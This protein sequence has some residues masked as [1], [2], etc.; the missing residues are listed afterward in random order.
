[1]SCDLEVADCFGRTV[2]LD[3]S[4]WEKH[5]NRHPEVVEYHNHLSI[6][7]EDPDFVVEDPVTGAYHFYRLGLTHGRHRDNYLKVI[8]EYYEG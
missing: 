4:N 7:V 3:H 2:R 6:A 1:V 5:R 8:V